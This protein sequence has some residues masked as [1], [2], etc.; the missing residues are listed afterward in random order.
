MYFDCLSY[1][2][3]VSSD[4]VLY[5]SILMGLRSSVMGKHLIQW[6]LEIFV[7]AWE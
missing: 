2:Y 1:M 3:V 7:V 4:Y 6:G 5:E